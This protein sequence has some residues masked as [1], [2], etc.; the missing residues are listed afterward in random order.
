M[1]NVRNNGMDLLWTLERICNTTTQKSVISTVWKNHY[2]KLMKIGLK[3]R[4]YDN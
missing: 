1:D 4:K 2:W 3:G